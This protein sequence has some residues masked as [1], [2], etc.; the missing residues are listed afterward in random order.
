MRLRLSVALALMVIGGAGLRRE[1]PTGFDP[2]EQILGRNTAGCSPPSRTSTATE[3][4]T[5]SWASRT[6]IPP[7]AAAVAPLP[8][9]GRMP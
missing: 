1:P 7:A 2:P 6:E 8:Q 4:W 9:P 5:C 3:R